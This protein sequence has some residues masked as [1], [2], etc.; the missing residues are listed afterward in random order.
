MKESIKAESNEIYKLSSENNNGKL[1]KVLDKLG[2]LSDNFDNNSL[3]YLLEHENEKVRC[4]AVKNLAKTEDLSLKNTYIKL[5]NKDDSSIVKREAASAIGR[6]RNKDCIPILLN[7]LSNSDPEV[8]MQAMRGLLVFKEDKLVLDS[9]KKLKDH[10]NEMIQEVIKKE[11]YSDSSTGYDPS[12]TQSPDYLKNATIY[13][14]SVNVLRF[15]PNNSI[16][17][18]FTSPPYYNARDYSTYLS[19]NDYLTFL[20][21]IFKE[22]HR[23]TKEGRFLVLNTSP[24]IIPRIGRQYSSKRYP[25]PYDIH[26]LLVKMGWE[27]IDDIVWAKPEASVKNR[28][29]GFLQH[30]KPLAY[31]PNAC[32]ECVMVY[33]KKTEKLIDW[34]IKQYP[35]EI[36][37]D[38][39]INGDYESSNIWEIDPTFDKT[40]SAVFPIELC[41]KIIKF[42]SFKGDL[43]FDPFAGSGTL[44]KSALN[45][46][47]YF[48]LIEKELKY[49][50]RIK[51][52]LG[53][54]KINTSNNIIPKFFTESEFKEA[55]K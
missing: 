38:S 4:L 1:I 36:V 3:I 35:K 8:A 53:Q 19:Y 24:I 17:L 6:L 34:N 21:S 12:H 16:H 22:I 45:L 44:G 2:K 10:P 27:F 42:Y 51:E 46:N 18:T 54:T 47:R 20:E 49:I 50:D 52:N 33:R 55:L 39:K 30:R 37:D 23:I 32:T 14:D 11:F 31:K 5:I 25:I 41:N 28:N 43:I 9:L 26:P 48:L 7:L 13:G 15:I 29:A 40:H